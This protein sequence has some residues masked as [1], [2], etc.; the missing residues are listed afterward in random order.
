M[1]SG[2]RK[3]PDTLELEVLGTRQAESSDNEDCG[4]TVR[5]LSRTHHQTYQLQT[6]QKEQTSKPHYYHPT[7]MQCISDSVEKPSSSLQQKLYSA[8]VPVEKHRHR[9]F[10]LRRKPHPASSILA[11]CDNS[12]DLTAPTDPTTIANATTTIC[13]SLPASQTIPNVAA[14]LTKRD[15]KKRRS[16]THTDSLYSLVTLAQS[17]EIRQ[18]QHSEPNVPDALA[19]TAISPVLWAN[20]GEKAKDPQAEM[21]ADICMNANN[22]APPQTS[23]F[24]DRGVRD[25]MLLNSELASVEKG[26]DG[27]TSA[28][29]SSFQGRFLSILGR[30]PVWKRSECMRRQSRTTAA[31]TAAT[32]AM[33]NDGL[34]G[35]NDEAESI[36]GKYNNKN[37]ELNADFEQFS[38]SPIVNGAGGDKSLRRLSQIRRR[39][40]SYYFS[41]KWS[42]IIVIVVITNS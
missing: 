33:T 22:D 13:T 7:K 12:S 24:L 17:G 28:P 34:L 32:A 3:R 30:L 41:G 35:V 40:S 10:H 20:S 29:V 9:W 26:V 1:P 31:A 42:H 8:S 11:A 21:K 5:V 38:M 39:R 14:V 4:V 15:S 2:N 18:Q 25:H 16:C 37:R 19:N 27:A 36:G 6:E 23:A